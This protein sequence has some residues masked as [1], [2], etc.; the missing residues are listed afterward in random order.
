MKTNLP[1]LT[2][3]AL[4]FTTACSRSPQEKAVATIVH[5]LEKTLKD[6]SS[7]I[8]VQYDIQEIM[9]AQVIGAETDS[10]IFPLVKN[11]SSGKWD[12]A[13][14]FAGWKILHKFKCR[15]ESGLV[16]DTQLTF[17]VSRGYII[18]KVR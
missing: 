18:E 16:K 8:P 4:L 15:S 14:R 13:G 1:I 17:Y 2:V 10:T 6:P 7:Y 5:H 3:L 12:G 11:D 9:E